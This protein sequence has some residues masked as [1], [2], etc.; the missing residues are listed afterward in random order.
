MVT[1][2]FP[3]GSADDNYESL[4]QELTRLLEH[5]A[6]ATEFLNREHY[7]RGL[8]RHA[9]NT[10][11][12]YGL[13][14]R[15]LDACLR[16]LHWHERFPEWKSIVMDALMVANDLHNEQL[17][18]SLY[19]HFGEFMRL[20][21]EQRMALQA[22]NIALAHLMPEHTDTELDALILLLRLQ[23]QRNLD[24]AHKHY[25]TRA[26]RLARTTG[27]LARRMEVCQVLS[28][29]YCYVEDFARA[30]RF[31][32]FAYR[33]ARLEKNEIRQA[34]CM[35]LFAVIARR[36]QQFHRALK[37]LR[38]IEPKLKGITGYTQYA[39]G[40]YEL[41]SLAYCRQDLDTAESLLHEA[42]QRFEALKMAH[43][44][45]TCI[46]TLALVQIAKRQFEAAMISIANAHKMWCKLQ[47]YYGVGDTQI[48]HAHL[49]IERG[50]AKHALL[51]LMRAYNY[52]AKVENPALRSNLLKQID[53]YWQKAVAMLGWN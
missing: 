10:P 28:H 12:T 53:E 13:A 3:I 19:V 18:A 7:I 16:H 29:I 43:H 6:H 41:G 5:T 51:R 35:L 8:L 36:R 46:Q 37:L 4:H 21:G 1:G 30:T 20:Q 15:L 31:A 9:I 48:V 52:C 25:I 44:A 27:S 38:F 39:A 49:E 34:D 14:I 45:A 50:R 32:A 17:Q 22:A 42:R 2:A 26:L 33:L 40:L 11:P 24:R 47:N 23:V